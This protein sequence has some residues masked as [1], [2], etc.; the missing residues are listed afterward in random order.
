MNTPMDTQIIDE[1]ARVVALT[2]EFDKVLTEVEDLEDSDRTVAE[3]IDPAEETSAQ[4]CGKRKADLDVVVRI[5]VRVDSKANEPKPRAKCR[6]VLLAVRQ[7][8]MDK[9]AVNF[10]VGVTSVEI[11]GRRINEREDGSQYQEAELYLTVTF[12][13]RT[14][15]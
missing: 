11:G 7:K 5:L 3:V 6:T 14:G 13:E 1:I 10:P 2:V 15:D 8:L 9:A 4:S 12:V